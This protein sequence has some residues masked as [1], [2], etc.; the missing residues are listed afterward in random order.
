M[1][2]ELQPHLDA[3]LDALLVELDKPQ[4]QIAAGAAL[5]A[6]ALAWCRIFAKAGFHAALGLLMLVP[7]LNLPVF[8]V[9]A[10]GAWPHQR[11]LRALRRVQAASRDADRA[12]A[13][14][15]AA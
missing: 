12:L 7:G 14:R 6:F 5:L 4:V 13:R 8:L 3:L 2:P 11:E 15:P 9:L 1:P 10:F